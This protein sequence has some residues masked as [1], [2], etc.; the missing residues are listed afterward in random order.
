MKTSSDVNQISYIFVSTSP[1][2][3]EPR[4]LDQGPHSSNV[5][6]STQPEYPPFYPLSL[7]DIFAEFNRI[8]LGECH[9]NANNDNVPANHNQP[10]FP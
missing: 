5:F 4:S 6:G 8:F 1:A 10:A 7:K 9:N 3:L 2:S